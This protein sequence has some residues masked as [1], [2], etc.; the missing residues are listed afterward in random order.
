MGSGHET[1]FGMKAGPEVYLFC[2]VFQVKIADQ[3]C[4]L[5]PIIRALKLFGKAMTNMSVGG[6]GGPR[7]LVR[8]D[9]AFSHFNSLTKVL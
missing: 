2:F 9:S 3:K 4:A 1:I 7:S 8:R 6:N 5:W